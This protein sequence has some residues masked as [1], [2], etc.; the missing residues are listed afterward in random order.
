M[1]PARTCSECG[2][3]LIGARPGTKTCSDSCRSKRSRRI[4][5]ANRE[6]EEFEQRSPEGAREIAA[7]IRRE[8]PDVIKDVV[9]DELRPIVRESLTEDT[10]RAIQR[11]LGLTPRAVELI[12]L[13]LENED[14]IIRQ[15]AY[16]LITKYTVGHP[17]LV[18]QDDADG[19]KQIVV[20]F[21]LPR[22]DDVP[23]E[24]VEQESEEVKTCD[25]CGE[26]KAASEFAAGSDRCLACFNH[27]RKTIMEEFT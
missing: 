14:P 22:P 8:S 11:L 24:V 18:K 26:D 4:R 25:L 5:R 21:N 6:A 10:L 17:A 16:T 12:A 20:N 2:E 27:W 23:A 7:I 3:P 9:R 15:R 13:D 19:S 1:P